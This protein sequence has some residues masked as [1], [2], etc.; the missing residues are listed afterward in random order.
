MSI[1]IYIRSMKTIILEGS[2][3]SG[4]TTVA[5]LLRNIINKEKKSVYIAE[6]DQTL[7]PILSNRDYKISLNHLIK[8]IRSAYKNPVDYVIFDR[9]HLTAS[10]ITS[11]PMKDY[12]KIEKLLLTK[13][14]VLVLLKIREKEIPQRIRE[15]IKY[16]GPSWGE[17]VNKKGSESQI[18]AHYIEAQRKVFKQYRSSQLPKMEFDTTEKNFDFIA[19]KIAEKVLK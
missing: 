7:M 12:E 1:F 18:N 17:Y 16:R 19:E 9:L 2:S 3:A 4:K 5:K 8:V 11:S 13:D 10:A 14:P 15:S 6:E